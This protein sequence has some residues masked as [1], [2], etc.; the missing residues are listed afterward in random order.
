[1]VLEGSHC[2]G[3]FGRRPT[4]AKFS[5]GLPSGRFFSSDA[6]FDRLWKPVGLKGRRPDAKKEKMQIVG[7]QMTNASIADLLH[8][9]RMPAM[10]APQEEVDLRPSHELQR[11]LG[12]RL[13]RGFVPARELRSEVKDGAL[14]SQ[15]G[16]EWGQLGFCR[17]ALARTAAQ[18]HFRKARTACRKTQ[19]SEATVFA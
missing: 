13:P 4:D 7:Q 12:D 18:Q 9:L 5:P 19:C 11:L 16:K 6:P 1:V 10:A 15:E 14:N 3:R 17:K 8:R 2:V